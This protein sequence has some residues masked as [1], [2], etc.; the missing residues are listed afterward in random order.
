MKFMFR[1]LAI[2]W[3]WTAPLVEHR[4]LE[5]SGSGMENVFILQRYFMSTIWSRVNL[6]FVGSSQGTLQSISANSIMKRMWQR[7]PTQVWVYT[8][9][10]LV[11]V[12]V[13]GSYWENWV[14]FFTELASV[15][16][17]VQYSPRPLR[18]A[19][20]NCCKH[21]DFLSPLPNRRNENT[22]VPAHLFFDML[23][24]LLL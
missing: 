12:T 16:C 9:R 4:Y 22:F 7:K 10:I 18:S 6:L 11:H 23:R 14:V 5:L 19:C 1:M 13:K 15:F 3:S 21:V 24:L 17:P 8:N 2:Q 20:A